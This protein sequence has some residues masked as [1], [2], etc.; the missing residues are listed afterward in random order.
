MIFC[1]KLKCKIKRKLVNIM[2]F[3]HLVKVHLEKL[4][5]NEYKYIYLKV[6]IHSITGHRVALKFI[7][8]KKTEHLSLYSRVKREIQYL[9]LLKHPHI[10]KL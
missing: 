9:K 4:N 8:K 2:C 6:A 7:S 10:I 3:R 5:V 1:K